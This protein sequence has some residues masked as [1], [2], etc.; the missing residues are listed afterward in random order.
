MGRDQV[1][2]GEVG[3]DWTRRL[4]EGLSRSTA[5]R[6]RLELGES[7]AVDVH[8]RDF[9]ADPLETVRRI[10]SDF[11]MELGAEAERRMRRFL[12]MHP[13]DEHGRHAYTL[14]GAGLDLETERGR[15]EAYQKRFGIP[16]EIAA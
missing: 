16:S 4:V 12:A 13:Q 1:D 11:G 3:A 7:R 5:V 9:L 14:K 2:P 10:Y 8:F 15:F 6:D